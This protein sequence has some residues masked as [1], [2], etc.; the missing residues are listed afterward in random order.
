M[1][2]MLFK[3][4]RL[5]MVSSVFGCVGHQADELV[6]QHDNVVW[7]GTGL[8]MALEQKAGRSV[9]S[10]P[11]SVPSNSDTWVTRA[12]AGNVWASTAKPWFLGR[13]KDLPRD[14]VL[15]RVV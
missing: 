6:E 5:G 2:R 9:N 14:Y 8:G 4:V 7:T 1:M 10:K 11:C 12:L 15:H 3:S 13:D